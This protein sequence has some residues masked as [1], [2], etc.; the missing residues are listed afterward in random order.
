MN[1]VVRLGT[2]WLF[3]ALNTLTG[4]GLLLAPKA[5]HESMF[6]NP[7]A[8]YAILGFSDTALD[9]LH[10]VLRGQGAALLAVSLFLFILGR[11]DKRSYLLIFLVCGLSLVAHAFTLHQHLNSEAVRR[12]VEDF[13]PLYGMMAVNVLVALGGIWTCARGEKL[14]GA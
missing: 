13:G 7:G 12:A 14:S 8:A 6:E 4:L 3:Q 5:F 2:F 9:M 10:N 1:A 11:R